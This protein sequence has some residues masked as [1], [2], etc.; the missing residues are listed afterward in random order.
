MF[1]SIPFVRSP[2]GSCVQGTAGHKAL[3]SGR[4]PLWRVEVERDV[5]P[6]ESLQPSLLH[7]NEE[8]RQLLL[9]L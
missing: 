4:A 7:L 5:L 2:Q 6:A 9:L 3:C 1:V 8:V